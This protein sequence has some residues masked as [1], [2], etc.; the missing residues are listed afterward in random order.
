[1]T[2]AHALYSKTYLPLNPIPPP[3]P[4]LHKNPTDMP[5]NHNTQTIFHTCPPPAHEH[6]F[7]P[8]PQTQTIYFYRHHQENVSCIDITL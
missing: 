4:P 5:Q 6:P 2:P 7:P 3:G 8:I 1:M